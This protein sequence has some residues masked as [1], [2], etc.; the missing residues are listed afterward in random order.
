[1]IFS[2]R[3]F[4]F[5][6]IFLKSISFILNK[7]NFFFILGIKSDIADNYLNSHISTCGD[8]ETFTSVVE[9]LLENK[10][11]FEE[12][13][14]NEESFEEM[15]LSQNPEE[16]IN[17]RKKLNQIKKKENEKVKLYFIFIFFF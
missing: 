17:E 11:Q 3:V 12:F 8:V 14:M 15:I 10:K 16:L 5:K 7:K 6:E 1:M 9:M 4:S 2:E 13:G